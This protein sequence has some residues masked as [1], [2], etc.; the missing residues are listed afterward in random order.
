MNVKVLCNGSSW[1]EEGGVGQ[2]EGDRDRSDRDGGGGGGREEERG[3]ERMCGKSGSKRESQMKGFDLHVIFFK[4]F[5]AGFPGTNSLLF[6][7]N[8]KM[9]RNR[10]LIFTGQRFEF[11]DSKIQMPLFM[12]QTSL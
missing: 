4:P 10:T 1:N 2:R 12:V 9:R 7:T 11:I 5:P 3:L 8:L 6:T